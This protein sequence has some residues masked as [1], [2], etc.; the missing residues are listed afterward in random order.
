LPLMNRIKWRKKQI[1]ITT[2]NSS[3]FRDREVSIMKLNDMLTT[4]DKQFSIE[5]YKGLGSMKPAD[6]GRVCM[7]PQYRNMYKI[8]EVGDVQRIF[9]LLGKNTAARK[10][11]LSRT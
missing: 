6:M 11:L 10:Q 8:T 2:K 4:L 3:E 5:R 9:A 1:Y 7:D